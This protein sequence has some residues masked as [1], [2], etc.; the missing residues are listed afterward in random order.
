MNKIDKKSL[1][2]KMFFTDNAC[3]NGEGMLFPKKI[4]FV[5][6]RGETS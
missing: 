2:L 5:N 3:C 1:W 6:R 4:K